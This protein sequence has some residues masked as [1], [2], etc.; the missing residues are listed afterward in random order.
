MDTGG[1]RMSKQA[2]W[3]KPGVRTVDFP[4]EW[5]TAQP[6]DALGGE[7][8]DG[9]HLGALL[10]EDGSNLLA[11]IYPGGARFARTAGVIDWGIEERY[12]GDPPA[13]DLVRAVNR[14]WC[15]IL[16]QMQAAGVAVDERI[17][18]AG[19]PPYRTRRQG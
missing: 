9:L 17:E 18:A 10:L 6:R 3:Q 8:S 5:G 14:E 13:A 16:G 12:I 4:H 2:P 11:L 15:K 7:I 19:L 1:R